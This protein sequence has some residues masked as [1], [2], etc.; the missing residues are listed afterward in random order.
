MTLGEWGVD[1]AERERKEGNAGEDREGQETEW[2]VEE[3]EGQGHSC[4]KGVK[5]KDVASVRP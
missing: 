4:D 1:G 2:E 3:D 5:M